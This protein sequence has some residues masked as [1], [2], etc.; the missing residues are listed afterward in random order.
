MQ[1][2]LLYSHVTFGVLMALFVL[3]QDKG[4]GLSSTFGGSG[5]FYASQRGAARVIHL[6]TVVFA[7]LFLLTAVLYVVA[8]PLAT[9][10][11]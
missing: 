5:G 9:L 8:D 1:E 2:Y 4:A 6:M 11:E 3:I 7:V 10:F